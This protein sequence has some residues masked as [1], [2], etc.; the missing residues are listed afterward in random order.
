MAST[1]STPPRLTRTAILARRARGGLRD[2][3][4]DRTSA[5]LLMLAA[6]A[7]LIWVN[8]PARA[9]YAAFWGTP[10]GVRV[11]G[12]E[13][14]LTLHSLVNDAL[15]A[16]FFF[17]VGLEVRRE[18]T[19][20]EL[21][22]RSRAI[23]PVAAAAGGLVVPA[24]VFLLVAGRSGHA[25]AWGVVIST[26]TA[27]L[28]GA[29]ALVGPR[30]PARLR[31]FLLTMAVVDDIGALAVIAVFYTRE[32]DPMPLAL[33]AVALVA[34]WFV[35]YLP[36]MR[37]P[38][39]A[40]LAVLVWLG[41]SRAGVHPTLAGVAMALLLPVSSPRRHQVE[42]AYALSRAFRQ[43]PNPRYAAAA[44]RGLRE[45][46]SVNE[47]LQ[48]QFEPFVAY[49]VLPVFALANA[50]VHLD[51]ASLGTSLRS[52]VMWGVVAGLVVGKLAG[53]TGATWLA[54]RTGR[55]VLA[56]GLT[57]G[58]VAG[59]AALSGIG[60]T[61]ALLIVDIALDGGEDATA[62]RLGVLVATALSV[63]LGW[64][65]F[66]ALDRFAPTA[67]VGKVL[68]R[69]FD[70]HRDRWRGNPDAPH[71]IVEY[72]DFECPFCS[73]ATGSAEEVL[74]ELGDEVAWVWRHLP[75]TRVHPHAVDAARAA[76]AAAL[77]GAFREY[78][79]MLFAHQD[80]LER[81]DLIAYAD[82]LGLDLDRFVEDLDSADVARR[83]Q[84][85]TDDAELMD[86]LATP[87]FFVDGRRHIGP[88]DAATLVAALRR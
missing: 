28:L 13:V 56:P 87:T 26:D 30:H 81:E 67:P 27:F 8:S 24:L 58:R 59:G 10:V 53:I 82:E 4:P 15:M 40:V 62:A 65:V 68:L 60:F 20:G 52:P 19:I 77:Q 39:Y 31:L 69:P 3:G 88:Y 50:G 74:A 29:L 25:A 75:L 43:S 79:P 71:V 41:L 42:R 64:A 48:M 5:A 61:I 73:R 36:S 16:V 7:A 44:S 6:L 21:S 14:A 54:R 49:V 55:G 22:N 78:G 38:A 85:D 76:E 1:T 18:V 51:A 47:R 2:L 33:T 32:L 80:A 37:G 11:G 9:G 23:V 34:V 46:I 66:R 12:S 17:T 86:L 45:S 84:E 63:A 57:L 70:P 72:G 83:V 35:R